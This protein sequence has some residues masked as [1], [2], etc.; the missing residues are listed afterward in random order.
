MAN[1]A[2]RRSYDTGISQTVQGD[3]QGITSRLETLIGQRDKEVAA[4]M[5]EFQ[6]DGVS[7]EYAT[8]ERRWHTAADEVKSIVALVRTTLGLNDET[9]ASTL[10]KAKSAVGGIG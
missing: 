7:D 2:D 8:V 1:A 5:A 6:A 10:S 4:A 9:A 3:L